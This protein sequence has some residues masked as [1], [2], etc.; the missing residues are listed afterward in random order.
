MARLILN[1]E[2]VDLVT[3]ELA[4]DIVMIGRAGLILTQDR[5][6]QTKKPRLFERDWPLFVTRKKGV[7]TAD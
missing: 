4:R 5:L 7:W 2:G 6:K 3:H 1:R